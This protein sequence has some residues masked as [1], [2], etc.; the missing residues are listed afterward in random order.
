ML[1]FNLFFTYNWGY[2]LS[3]LLGDICSG[4]VL[5]QWTLVARIGRGGNSQVWS[6]KNSSDD[7]VAIKILTKEKEIAY[8]RFS[9]EIS[10]IKNN[11]KEGIVKLIDYSLPNWPLKER[12]WYSMPIGISLVDV[13]E[14]KN[15]VELVNYFFKISSVLAELHSKN[16]THRDIKP[17]NILLIDNNICLGDFGLVDYPEKEDITT[18]REEL[19]ARWTMAPEIRRHNHNDETRP[20]DVYS[21]AKSLW[22]TI[23]KIKDGFDGQYQKNGTIS[24]KNYIGQEFVGTLEDLLFQATEHQASLRPSMD[25]FRDSLQAWLKINSN[26]EMSNTV[27]WEYAQRNVFPSGTPSHAKWEKIDSI[28]HI[29]N[30]IGHKTNLNHIFFPDGG[31]LDLEGAYISKREDGCIE[32]ITDGI[33]NLLKPSSLQFEGFGI[34]KEWDYFRLE[35]LELE[36]SG[37]YTNISKLGSEEVVDLGAGRYI[38]GEYWSYGDYNGEPLPPEAKRL[39]RYMKGTFVIFQKMSSYNSISDTYD[40]RHSQMNATEFRAHIEQLIAVF[41][42]IKAKQLN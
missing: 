20:S 25:E 27:E 30:L 13:M 36:P 41:T 7:K 4:M 32:I 5:G 6:A 39:V 17:A 21:L 16:I 26:F 2:N 19:G 14:E 3:T 23:T 9:D 31:G 12:A 1:K 29:L 28:V 10:I 35:C 22:I 24:I 37:V 18:P 11:Q 15:L 42:K 40:G 8:K 33:I 34:D 38:Q